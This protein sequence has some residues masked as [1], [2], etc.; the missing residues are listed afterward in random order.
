MKWEQTSKNLNIKTY[1]FNIF[2]VGYKSELSGKEAVFDVLETS[3]WANIIAITKESMVVMV[4]QF[5]FGTAEVTLEF[6]SGGIDSGEAP[7]D[8]ARRELLEETGSISKSLVKTGE[9]KANPGFLNNT[10][11]HYL[12]TDVEMAKGQ[13]LDEFEEVSIK[14][15]PLDDIET[16]IL[17]GKINHSLSVTAWYYYKTWIKL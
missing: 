15:V 10:C 6:P 14:L 8:A 13:S 11:H 12:A 7:I 16:L 5:R 4:E 9:C 3:D 1:L 2:K 17:S